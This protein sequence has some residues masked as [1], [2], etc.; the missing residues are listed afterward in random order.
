MDAVISL[1][2]FFTLSR[3]TFSLIL[4]YPPPLHYLISSLYWKGTFAKWWDI[5]CNFLS[6]KQISDVNPLSAITE[7]PL[8]VC[9]VDHFFL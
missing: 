1:F 5:K 8:Q 9:P 2:F 4:A 7:S 6:C 3:E